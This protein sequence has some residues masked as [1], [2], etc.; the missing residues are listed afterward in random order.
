M[1][2]LVID[3]ET[4][5]LSHEK[6]KVL[7][8]GMLHANIDAD[9]FE[10]IDKAH[11][12]V[13]HDEYNQN[14]MALRINKINLAEH[15]KCSIHPDCACDEINDFVGRNCLTQAP[16]LGHNLRFD[17]RFL[18]ALHLQGGRDFG[19]DGESVDTML[20][21]RALRARGHVP[22]EMKS[23]LKVLSKY[24]DVSYKGAHDALEDCRITAEVYQK[25]L[26][27]IK[28]V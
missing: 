10:I 7:T 14:W 27:L 18:K 20:I 24:F 22:F 8:V 11:I 1:R 17:F 2:H 3:C 21:W 26:G 6:N 23:S 13:K 9:D 25:L 12:K 15:H 5:G 28:R 19:I 16:V 4:S